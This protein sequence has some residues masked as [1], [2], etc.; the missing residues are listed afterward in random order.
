LTITVLCKLLEW[1]AY[2][3]L[4]RRIEWPALIS[5]LLGAPAVFFYTT[6]KNGCA[7]IG[8]GVEL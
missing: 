5:S 6:N 7:I 1:P 8:L 4:P 2:H 3:A